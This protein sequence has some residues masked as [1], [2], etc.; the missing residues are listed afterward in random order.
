[1][2][3]AGRHFLSDYS[4][5]F[6]QTMAFPCL[7]PYGAGDVTGKDRKLDVTMTEANAHLLRYCVHEKNSTNPGYKYP[8]ANHPSWMHWAQNTAERH[9]HNSQKSVYLNKN[10]KDDNLR[11]EELE[12]IIREGGALGL[13]SSLEECKHLMQT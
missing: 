4:E 8:F 2:P 11:E 3:E 5:P 12:E 1:M 7:F 9:R 10:P 13:N 6:L